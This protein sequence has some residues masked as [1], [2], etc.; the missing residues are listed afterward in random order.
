MRQQEYLA[1]E[2]S[3]YG[4]TDIKLT[5]IWERFLDAVSASL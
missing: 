5:V 3:L 2:M 1:M 4:K